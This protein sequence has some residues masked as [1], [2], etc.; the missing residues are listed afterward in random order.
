[1]CKNVNKLNLQWTACNPTVNLQMKSAEVIIYVITIHTY[2]LMFG[3][4]MNIMGF[5]NESKKF[6][7][8]TIVN[9]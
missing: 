1:M 9:Y 5:G 6:P 2:V 7:I 4:Y 3:K 8:V